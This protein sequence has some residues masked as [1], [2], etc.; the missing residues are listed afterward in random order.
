MEFFK[1]KRDIPF[2][3]H[4]LIFNVISALTFVAAVFFLVT[5]GLHFSVEFTGGTKMEL[6][7]PQAAN[8]DKIRAELIKLG[9]EH[10][11]VAAER[12]E[13]IAESM[14]DPTRLLAGTDCGFD[15]SAGRGRVSADVVW[16]KLASMAEGACLASTRML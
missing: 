15:T 6:H 1:I 8:Q 4:A 16:A 3:R 10:P 2:M 5:K 7:Y 9:V 13:R 12:L 11:E 14:G